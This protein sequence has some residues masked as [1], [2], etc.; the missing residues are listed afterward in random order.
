MSLVGNSINS[1]KKLVS[2]IYLLKISM[3]GERYLAIVGHQSEEQ[4]CVVFSPLFL[5]LDTEYR[6][7]SFYIDVSGVF[8]S[9]NVL[10]TEEFIKNNQ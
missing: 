4:R 2:E 5:T 1:G 8:F 6:H 10:V 9:R 3:E 7:C